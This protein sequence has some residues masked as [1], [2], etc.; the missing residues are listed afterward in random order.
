MKSPR[1]ILLDFYGTVVEEDHALILQICA[2]IAEGSPLHI[3]ATDV[4]R[5]WSRLF[6]D[7]CLNSFD[8]AFQSQKALEHQSLIQVL[9]HFQVDRDAETLSQ[10]LYDYWASPVIYP[11]SK[12][13]LAQCP[14]PICLLSNIDTT[15]LRT[16]LDAH[17][18]HFTHTISS[19]DCR[20]YKP[21]P[22]MFERALLLLSLSPSEVL[23]VGDSLDS[24]VRGA[25]AMGIPVLWMNRSHRPHPAGANAPDYVT[26][27]LTGLLDFF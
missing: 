9:E 14:L 3:T 26:H 24:D 12:R 6:G 15:D 27:D 22:A 19:E 18:L 25:R 1:A 7:L 11:E 8:D 2:Q 10:P 21:R 17:D 20:A 16:A 4:G 5:Y 13:V 23:H